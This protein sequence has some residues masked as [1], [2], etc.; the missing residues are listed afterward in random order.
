[1]SQRYS[2]P[3]YE[4]SADWRLQDFQCAFVNILADGRE[5]VW[6]DNDR[7]LGDENAS[8]SLP[9]VDA[10]TARSS[11]DL[12]CIHHIFRGAVE[13]VRELGGDLAAHF[14]SH[15]PFPQ[16]KSNGAHHAI[17]TKLTQSNFAKF[18]SQLYSCSDREQKPYGCDPV[19]PSLRADAPQHPPYFYGWISKLTPKSDDLIRSCPPLP[20]LEL[21]WSP[22]HPRVGG[23][24]SSPGS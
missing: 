2:I 6:S 10:D 19:S 21:D 5:D 13:F 3:V 14:H 22:A 15:F 16:S 9:M 4:F 18:R 17:N 24:F 8:K 20:R 7:E 23:H 12:V 11:L 1:M